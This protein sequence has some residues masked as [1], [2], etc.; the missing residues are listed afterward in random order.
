MVDPVLVDPVQD[1]QENLV[2]KALE[3]FFTNREEMPWT[4]EFLHYMKL[5]QEELNNPPEAHNLYPEVKAFLIE[6]ELW[7]PA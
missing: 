3:D 2:A 5:E 6:R 1:H 4:T 7:F